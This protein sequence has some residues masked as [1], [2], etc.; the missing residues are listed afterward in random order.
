MLIV[1]LGD[2]IREGVLDRV[3]VERLYLADLCA[4]RPVLVDDEYVI[5]LGEPRLRVVHVEDD[6]LELDIRRPGRVAVILGRQEEH[7]LVELFEVERDGT[8]DRARV[9]V[10]ADQFV[11]IVADLVR[12]EAV[13]TCNQS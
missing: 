8:G 12:Y 11:G 13:L 1:E 4:R 10:D 2:G 6:E 7:E 5:V 3:A 9:P